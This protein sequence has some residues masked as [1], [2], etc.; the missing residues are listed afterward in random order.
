MGSRPGRALQR[1][2]VLAGRRRPDAPLTRTTPFTLLD[3][4]GDEPAGQPPS[5]N[6]H[7]LRPEQ[8]RSLGLMLK[9]EGWDLGVKADLTNR[10]RLSTINYYGRF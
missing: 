7:P 5:F 6:Q 3:N 2:M 8:L 4:A 10:F 9:R 1:D